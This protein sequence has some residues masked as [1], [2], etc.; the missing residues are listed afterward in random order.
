MPRIAVAGITTAYVGLCLAMP[1]IAVGNPGG[2]PASA[3]PKIN[4]V[5]CKTECSGVAYA[6]TGSVLVL[7]GSGLDTAETVTFLGSLKKTGDE[8]SVEP[9]KVSAKSITV[10]VH[11]RTYNQDGTLVAEFKRAVLVP[12]KNPG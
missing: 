10:R 6:R 11:T 2:A 3:P 12:R 4:S 5:A 7:K 1:A 9:E 8:V